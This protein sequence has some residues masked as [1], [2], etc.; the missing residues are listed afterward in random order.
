MKKIVLDAYGVPEDVARCLDAPDIGAPSAGE[1][2]FDV[3]AF[4]INPADIGFCR[5]NYRIRPPLP[6]TPG[7]ECVGRVAAVGDGVTHVKPDDLVIN[8]QRENWAARRRVKAEDAV[9]IPAGLDLRQA[10]MLRINPPTA[11]LMLSDLVPL[12]RGDW[13]IQNVAN[14]AV[15]RLVI[16]LAKA[17]GIRTV[18][19]T[20][21]EDVFPELKALG[22]DICLTDG[23]D[24]ADRV[25]EATG[26]AEIPLGLDAVSGAA[27]ARIAAC[28]RDEGTICTYGSMTGEAP[29]VSVAD[30]V[31]RGMTFTGFMLGRFM[32]R[33]SAEEIRAIY[34]ELGDE[35]LKGA[36]H[37]PVDSVYPIEDIREALIRAQTGGRQGK[38]L[39]SPGG[40]IG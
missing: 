2:V 26:A 6:A 36:I 10:A 4:P 18:N 24:L 14:S 33:R 13:V 30:V 37:A 40:E 7:A 5:G 27:T 28:L 32:A 20:R 31:F 12:K 38:V 25:R 39:V 1:V 23:P 11:L 22:A 16:T 29:A 34:A 35:M 3:I 9:P 19:V 17:K 21:R 15:G 8:L